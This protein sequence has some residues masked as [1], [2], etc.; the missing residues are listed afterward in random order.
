[1]DVAYAVVERGTWAI[2]EY[3][4]N[5]GDYAYFEGHYYSDKAPGTSFLAIPLYAVYSRAGTR[6]LSNL[7]AERLAGNPALDSFTD[8]NN[9]ESLSE[10]IYRYGAI[11]LISFV[12]VAIP[13]ALLA[14]LLFRLIR[15]WTGDGRTA[16]VLAGAYSIA[17]PA[18]AYANNLY[19]HQVAAFLLVLTFFL[20]YSAGR[21]SRA[22]PYSLLAGFALGAVV[23]VEYQT[24]LIAGALGLYALV[25][26]KN[27]WLIGWMCLAALPPLALAAFYNWSIFHTPLPVGYL[28]SPLYSDLHH[29]GLISLTYPKPDALV[30]LMFGARRGL[31]LISPFLLLSVPGFWYMARMRERRA[32]FLVCL[33]SV[34]SFWLFNSSSAMWQGGFAVGPRYLLPSLPFMTLAIAFFVARKHAQL[35]WMGIAVLLSVSLAGVWILTL[36]GQ[37]FPQYQPNP[38]LEYSLPSLQSGDIARNLGMLFGLRGLSSIVPLV[39]VLGGLM[40]I[41]GLQARR[42]HEQP[43]AQTLME[44]RA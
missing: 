14:V 23:I 25:T 35:V 31:F 30:E 13:S 42:S 38:W 8:P 21:G 9:S 29:T 24:A 36:G 39:F 43:A 4:Q 34:A 19:G 10:K 40:L 22:L 6:P 11:V 1:M 17:T 2:D 44:R 16:F 41:Y 15:L 12:G 7:L 28:Y 32:E 27:K 3:F 37:Q 18:L 26:L 5:T 33:W 20:L